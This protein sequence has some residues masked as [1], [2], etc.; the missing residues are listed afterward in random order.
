MRKEKINIL[1]EELIKV[2]PITGVS[3][4]NNDNDWIVWLPEDATQAQRDACDAIVVQRP[5][6][7]H[8]EKSCDISVI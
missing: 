3:S 7:R 6:S 5:A 4:T 2:A 1:T 8:N